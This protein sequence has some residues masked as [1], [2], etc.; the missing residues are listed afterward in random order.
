M[1]DYTSFNSRVTVVTVTH[2]SDRFIEG[3]LDSLPANI[4]V[5]IYDN[6]TSDHTLLA[7]LAERDS[8]QVLFSDENIG[9]GRGCNIGASFASTEFFLFLNPDSR[10]RP[11]TISLLLLAADTYPD[12]VAANPSIVD[13]DG[14]PQFKRRSILLPRSA[15]L[16]RS[17][18]IK[19]C[20]LPVLSGAALFVQRAAFEAVQGFDPNLF[21]FFEDDDLSLRLAHSGGLLMFVHDALV[22]HA[23]GV[24]SGGTEASERIKA[25]HWGYSSVYVMAKHRLSFPCM[26]AIL[27]M[28]PR[29]LS[30]LALMSRRK[31]TKYS[32]RLAGMLSGCRGVAKANVRPKSSYD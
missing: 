32:Q 28:L 2:N 27:H 10:L 23:G 6:A 30:P 29:A 5:I 22:E 3:M 8:V 18:P 9:F 13:K 14:R 15:W 20:S 11:D 12:M 31:R 21:L 7:R 17:A 26:R 1:T 19:H 24:S 25:W 4:P 16:G